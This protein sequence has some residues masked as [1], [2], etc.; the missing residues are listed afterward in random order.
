M[1]MSGRWKR[2]LAAALVAVGALAGM[3]CDRSPSTP[4][5][6]PSKP[7]AGQAAGS[8]EV[9]ADTG[10]EPTPHGGAIVGKATTQAGR[11]LES[12]A[13]EYGP[14]DAA[15]A[16]SA[17]APAGRA[18]GRN[19]RYEIRVPADGDYATWATTTIDW[20]GRPL[21]FA[22]EAEGGQRPATVTAARGAVR[23][24]AWKLSG[25]RPGRDQADDG[26]GYAAATY[27]AFLEVNAHEAERRGGAVTDPGLYKTA[28]EAEVEVT[29]TPKGKLADGSTGQP[30]VRRVPVI[31]SGTRSGGIRDVPVGD[32]TATAKLV[33]ASGKEIA[34]LRI[35]LTR[36][37]S[38]AD[39]E[40]YTL[41][42]QPSVEVVFDEQRP[43]DGV[44]HEAIYV[45]R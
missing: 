31:K 28:R 3:G 29:L 2:I 43:E 10:A 34:P 42:Y 26:S 4:S 9:V 5:S 18:E 30:I 15:A 45:G 39:Y 12:F 7:G 37:E 21:T 11:P 44:I 13:V 25:P 32:Y 16:Q 24:Y 19:G 8:N 41:K 6:G 36:G 1:T 35:S 33:D 23:N 27:G 17:N 40:N 14:P 20:H 22:L 38:S